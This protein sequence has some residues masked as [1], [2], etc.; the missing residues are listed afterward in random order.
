MNDA[1]RVSVSGMTPEGDAAADAYFRD[2][3]ARFGPR[4]TPAF[5]A[6][7]DALIG[8]GK[9]PEIAGVL[10]RVTHDQPDDASA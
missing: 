3:I 9:L 2:A 6:W 4:F 8:A 5:N 7:C 10:S 1:E